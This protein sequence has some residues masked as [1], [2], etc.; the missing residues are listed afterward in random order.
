MKRSST[1]YMIWQ[2]QE[3]CFT[4]LKKLLSFC[5]ALKSVNQFHLCFLV[6]FFQVTSERRG[7]LNKILSLTALILTF[8]FNSIGVIPAVALSK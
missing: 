6:C 7:A 3:K 8:G 1:H 4:Q 2:K 5:I